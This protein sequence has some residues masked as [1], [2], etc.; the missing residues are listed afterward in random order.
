MT[1]ASDPIL[2][3]LGRPDGPLAGASLWQLEVVS[4]RMLTPRMR[5][6]EFTGPRLDELTYQPGQDLM[7]RIPSGAGTINRRYT[8]RS[9]DR[10]R[11]VV[12]ID[13][14]VHGEGRGSQ[15]FAAAAP[16]DRIDAI[17]PRGKIVVVDD[18]AWHLFAGDESALPAMLAMSE[19]VPAG[20]RTIVLAEV[21]DDRE[22]QSVP[23]V[24]IEIHWLHR[25]QVEPGNS[26]V[27]ADAIAQ[28]PLIEGPGRVY[29][30]GESK[31][32]AAMRRVLIER[33]VPAE[34]ISAKPYWSRGRA[35]A[36]HGEPERTS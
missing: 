13:A 25:G 27:L 35:N 24:M 19:S 22:Q 1:D 21:A 6:V 11:G 8:I 31:S 29:L 4:A 36:A 17:G 26:T 32:V 28:L 20:R 18:V 16:G 33:G 9:V 2:A 34:S 23:G 12:T 30:A 5:R 15:W 10:E 3:V 7:L 14:V